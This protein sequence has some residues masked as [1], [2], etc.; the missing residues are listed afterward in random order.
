MVCL[1]AFGCV[2]PALHCT[3]YFCRPI[4]R[5]NLPYYQS[6]R[7]Q[8]HSGF[9]CA[10]GAAAHLRV[11]RHEH[12]AFLLVRKC[13]FLEH[14][15]LSP[16]EVTQSHDRVRDNPYIRVLYVVELASV[17]CWLFHSA[18]LR[19]DRRRL[20]PLLLALWPLRIQKKIPLI[21]QCLEK[22]PYPDLNLAREPGTDRIHPQTGLKQDKSPEASRQEGKEGAT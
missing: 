8:T 16:E 19:G 7:A 3:H 11:P 15:H 5:S 2:G 22:V 20:K 1:G 18:S 6:T 21:F 12:V 13:L 17:F 10:S 4:A 14:L 9:G